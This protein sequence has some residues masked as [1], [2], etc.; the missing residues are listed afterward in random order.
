LTEADWPNVPND[1]Q[2]QLESEI[3]DRY[4]TPR[5]LPMHSMQP[6]LESE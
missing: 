5:P 4:Y 2:H 1:V 3:I 6:V